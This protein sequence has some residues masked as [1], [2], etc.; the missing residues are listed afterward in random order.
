MVLEGRSFLFSF[1]G[2]FLK[3]IVTK[4]KGS[5]LFPS[6]TQKLSPSALMVLGG[7]LPGRVGRCDM[8]KILHTICME[9]FLVFGLYK[10][11]DTIIIK[12]FCNIKD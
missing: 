12:V 11:Y 3:D 8:N 5:H 1:E 4:A 10:K 9:D 6:R 7:R 2:T